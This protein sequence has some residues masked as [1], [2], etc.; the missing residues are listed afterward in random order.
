MSERASFFISR[1]I[2][3]IKVGKEVSQPQT[4]MPQNKKKQ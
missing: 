2:S 4:I 1:C 3:A